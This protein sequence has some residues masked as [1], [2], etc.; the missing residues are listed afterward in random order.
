MNI[1]SVQ[2]EFE[3]A[4]IAY[5]KT[6]VLSIF[7][8]FISCHEAGAFIDQVMVPVM[9]LI[10]DQWEKGDLSLSQVYLSS[11]LCEEVVVA[12]IPLPANPNENKA[13][14]AI[15]TLEDHHVLGKRILAATLRANGYAF[16]DYGL[17]IPAKKVIENV[18][19]DGTTILLISVLMINS[20]LKVKIITDA[21]KNQS[22]PV[23]VLVGGAPFRLD[24]LLWQ[25]VDADAT[26]HT[27]A[28]GIQILKKWCS[29]EVENI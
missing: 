18:V 12:R 16:T 25:R 28:Q 14:I 19:S 9:D 13:K 6:S 21:F 1:L 2:N 8:E 24:S 23:K 26:G 3:K 11:K 22:L 15:V 4:I 10:G 17:G 29:G 20:A 27:A 7:N 5:D